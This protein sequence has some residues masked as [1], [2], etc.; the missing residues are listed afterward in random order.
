MTPTHI[1]MHCSATKDSGTVSWQAIRRYH[2]ETKHWRDIGYHFGV[3][4]VNTEYEILVGRMPGEK[5]AHCPLQDMNEKAVGI[6]VVGDFDL[7]EPSRVQWHLAARIVR[8]LRLLLGIPVENVIG[9]RE[10]DPH[11][12]CPGLRFDMN[13]FRGEVL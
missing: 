9:H 11:K 1:M 12:T 6:C 13:L 2:I 4:L 5:G 8:Y 3:E 10:I 7:V